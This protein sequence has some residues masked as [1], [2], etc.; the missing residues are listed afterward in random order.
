MTK[1]EM[2]AEIQ[3]FINQYD[4]TAIGY[5]IKNKLDNADNNEDCIEA[6]YEEIMQ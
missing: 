1:E 5:S 2:I 3:S 4:G 6:I